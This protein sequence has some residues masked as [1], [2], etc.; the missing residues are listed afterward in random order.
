MR[1]FC[2]LVP[3]AFGMVLI[4]SLYINSSDCYVQIKK[5]QVAGCG[6]AYS[7]Y[8][9]PTS[10]RSDLFVVAFWCNLEIYSIDVSGLRQP[11][12]VVVS[13]SMTL[14]SQSLKCFHSIR[15]SR[16]L[17]TCLQH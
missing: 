10:T 12:V 3:H 6:R 8:Q 5:L 13:G 1:L 2:S 11:E 14:L 17:K 9:H 16:G 7:T 15:L 4:Q